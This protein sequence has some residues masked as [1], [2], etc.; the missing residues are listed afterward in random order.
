M[1]YLSSQAAAETTD[2]GATGVLASALGSQA[3]AN[4]SE[5]A[6]P[7]STGIPF[8]STPG[9]NAELL[10]PVKESVPGSAPTTPV[11]IRQINAIQA[12]KMTSKAAPT[13]PVKTGSSDSSQ[14]TMVSGG[15][16]PIGYKDENYKTK[17]LDEY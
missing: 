9:D 17:Y 7:S 10:P 5:L 14:V 6:G 12:F 15:F 3:D 8:I 1:Q 16:L 4:P 2:I 11:A 13:E